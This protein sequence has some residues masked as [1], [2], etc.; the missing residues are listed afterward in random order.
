MTFTE[1]LPTEHQIKTGNIFHDVVNN[2][3]EIL[4][5]EQRE[6]KEQKLKYISRVT[7]IIEEDAIIIPRT[8]SISVAFS[9]WQEEARTMGQKFPVSMDVTV[10]LEIFYYHQELTPNIRKVEIRDALW[11]L[12]RI[13]RRNSDLNGFST[14]GAKIVSGSVGNRGRA[15]AFYAGGRIVMEVPVL[16]QERRGITPGKMG[17]RR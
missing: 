10:T 13:L 4:K 9:E 14:K 11:E 16:F 2:V 8:P 12:S 3:I 5:R 1:C 17:Q 6:D 7:E 15:N